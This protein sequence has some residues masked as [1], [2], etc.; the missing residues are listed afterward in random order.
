[1]FC[2][3][4]FR[5]L[6]IHRAKGMPTSF[7]PLISLNVK[8]DIRSGICAIVIKSAAHSNISTNKGVFSRYDIRWP[9]QILKIY[10]F[11]SEYF[12]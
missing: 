1:M 5:S 3:S 4:V 7:A 8:W 11:L 9:N 2:L 12:K 10:F 6:I